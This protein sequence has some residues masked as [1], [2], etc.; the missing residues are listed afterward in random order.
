MELIRPPTKTYKVFVGGK[1]TWWLEKKKW[2]RRKQERKWNKFWT[3]NCWVGKTLVFVEC[4]ISWIWFDKLQAR[5][6]WDYSWKALDYWEEYCSLKSIRLKETLFKKTVLKVLSISLNLKRICNSANNMV[7]RNIAFLKGNT[8]F[9]I[10]HSIIKDS[11]NCFKNM[12]ANIR[13]SVWSLHSIFLH[14]QLR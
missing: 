11:T 12:F 4:G 8:F 14:V 5:I 7:K 3:V 2:G 13:K 10:I 6:N 1:P 9:D